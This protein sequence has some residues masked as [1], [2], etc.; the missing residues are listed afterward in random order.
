MKVLTILLLAVLFVLPGFSAPVVAQVAT[1]TPVATPEATAAATE[2]AV[3]VVAPTPVET[4]PTPLVLPAL[5]DSHLLI[6]GGVLIILAVIGAVVYS[7][8][9]KASRAQAVALAEIVAKQIRNSQPAMDALERAGKDLVPVGALYAVLGMAL[10]LV[11]AETEEGK[12]LQA[13]VIDLF[14]NLTDG[15]PWTPP[16]DESRRTAAGYVP[17][18]GF[19]NPGDL[20][21]GVSVDEAGRVTITP[22]VQP[23]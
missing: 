8:S 22:E 12:R 17:V 13:G 16:V 3:I 14:K 10:S 7:Q 9:S 2:P 19:E 21:P 11:P 1:N 5:R 6:G 20:L 18:P 15:K 4:E 23:G